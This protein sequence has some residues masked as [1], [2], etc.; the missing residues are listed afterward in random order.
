MQPAPDALRRW[1]RPTLPRIALGKAIHEKTPL[2]E[3]ARRDRIFRRSLAFA[4]VVAAALALGTCALVF[5]DLGLEAQAALAL[6]LV[7][8]AGKLQ[9]IYDRDDLLI[10]KT[11]I[12]QA[13]QLFQ[14][15]T[16]YSLLVFVLQDAFVAGAFGPTHVLVLWSALFVLLVLA[17]RLSRGFARTITPVERCLFVGSESSYER[18][19]VKLASVAGRGELVG[20]MS[21]GDAANDEIVPAAATTMHRLI[22][23]LRVHRV[24]IEPT[25][26]R[27]QATLDFI[28]EAKATGARV[29]VLPRILEVVGSAMEMDDLNGL[30]LLG[31]RRFGLS[32]SSLTLK[33]SFDLVVGGLGM[34]LIAPLLAFVALTIRID[35]PG[36]VIYRQ[37]RVGRHG[38]H[39]TIWKF[40]TMVDGADALKPTLL[41]LNESDGLFKIAEDPRVTR[42]GGILRRFSLDELPQLVNVLRGEMS[43]VGPRPLVTDED[44]RITGLDR[45]RLQLTPGMTGHWQ[46]LGS[47]R[48]PLAEMIKLDY[49][50]VSG[51]SLWSDL[52]ILMRTL[53]YVLA[54]RGM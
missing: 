30:T 43:L 7:V 34:V 29:S 21:L 6:P 26:A 20:R 51:W 50:Y 4:D 23:D 40:R 5:D 13:P 49:L 17:R 48:V 18:L 42:V 33:R 37:T 44:A 2:D 24:V 31:L 28:R 19:R 14:L 1:R 16:L 38:R 25:D 46:I 53:P 35:S 45:R 12:D 11:T 36:P 54:R 3:V 47:A 15:A 32:R 9:G 10:N 52:K 39:F 8:V 41:G 22:E 27:P